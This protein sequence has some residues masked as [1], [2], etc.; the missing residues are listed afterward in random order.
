M[1]D[2]SALSSKGVV[3]SYVYDAFGN[4]VSETG[5]LPFDNLFHYTGRQFD[6]ESGLYYYRARYYDPQIGR[7][8][9]EDPIGLRGGDVNFYSYVFNDPINLVDPLGQRGGVFGGLIGGVVG[10][11]TGGA[12]AALGGSGGGG[13]VAGIVGGAL[14]G[15]IAGAIGGAGGLFGGVTGA[16]QGAIVAG[17]SGANPGGIFGGA[18]GGGIGGAVGGAIGGPR[19]AEVLVGGNL[20]LGLGN[21]GTAIG[22]EIFDNITGNDDRGIDNP[23]PDPFQPSNLNDC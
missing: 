11:I 5:E 19:A 10:G 4:I 21:L 6:A 20:S 2:S 16:A 23:I 18:F 15:G 8:I 9:S 17:V 13:I 1:P 12:G 14:A 7:F 22:D 3:K